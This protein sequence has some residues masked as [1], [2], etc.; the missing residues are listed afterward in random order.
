MNQNHSSRFLSYGVSFALMCL[1][2]AT[3]QAG[4]SPCPPICDIEPGISSLQVFRLGDDVMSAV[5]EFKKKYEFE[6]AEIGSPDLDKD[7]FDT[8]QGVKLYYKPPGTIDKIVITAPGFTTDQGTGVYARLEDVLL[9]YGDAYE[10]FT[11]ED[12]DG[13]YIKYPDLGIGFDI[14]GTTEIVRAIVV[15]VPERFQP[16]EEISSSAADIKNCP[17]D[18]WCAY[19][20]TVNRAWR[21]S[22]LKQINKDNVT[23]LRPAWIF[24]PGEAI[25]LHSTPLA[26]EGN[27][28]VATNSSTVWKL[29]GATGERIWAAFTEEVESSKFAYV[30]GLAIGDGRVYTSL[31]T[32][33]SPRLTR[34]PARLSGTANWPIFERTPRISAAPALLLI[35]TC[36]SSARTAVIIRLG[37]VSSASI[38]R[39][40]I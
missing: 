5:A 30:R 35:L 3:A 6:E 31:A 40:G 12:D 8:G 9:G 24:M 36:W 16:D 38:L 1:I 15:F 10:P 37:V 32:A 4:P 2:V 33:V 13:Y 22:P 25:G 39:M 34:K 18:D 28:Y 14:D 27:I 20:R 23:Q 11:F 7:S 21:H 17:P 29:N 19:H 26:V